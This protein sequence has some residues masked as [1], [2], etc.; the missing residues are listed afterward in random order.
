MSAR[1]TLLGTATIAA[2]AVM[3]MTAAVAQDAEAPQAESQAMQV[4][5]A[6]LEDFVD[7]AMKVMALRQTFE[8]RMQAAETQ[9]DRQA[10]VQQAQ[11]EMRTAI[12]ETEG[13]DVETY[14]EIGEATQAD[15][16]LNQR[17]IALIQERVPQGTQEQGDG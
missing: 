2:L 4:S 6:M 10:L 14:T 13:M 9:E 16:A 5:D 15:E 7:A 1:T 8:T 3:P 11:T 17:I 12:D